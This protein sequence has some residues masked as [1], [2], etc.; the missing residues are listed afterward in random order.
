MEIQSFFN[1][2]WHDYITIAPAAGALHR[3]LEKHRS[4]TIH[5]D[6]VAFRTYDIA[7]IQLEAL[8]KHILA[9]GYEQYAP[10]H[11]EEKKLRAFGY[12]HKERNFPKIFLSELETRF[13]SQELQDVVKQICAQIDPKRV[14]DPSIMWA[15]R[16]WEPISYETYQRLLEESEYAAWVA[17]M[18]LR[19][20]HFTIDVNALKSIETIE[21]MLD[22]VEEQ[23][24]TLNTSGGRV[25]GSPEVLL[26]QGSTM[27][28]Q[29]SVTFA[30]N[31]TRVIPSCYY[32]FAKRYPDESGELYQ[33]FVAASADKI[34]ESTDVKKSS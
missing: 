11:F 34:F 25:K 19:A 22:F 7:P 27:A 10:Y 17:A 18:G 33:G 15:G 6:H 28:D 8:E 12:V 4:E 9:L 2:L 24:Y 1:Y 31:E 29:V 32:E 23:G 3:A 16:L 5:N 26:E 13:F 14:D 20:N 21:E 30:N